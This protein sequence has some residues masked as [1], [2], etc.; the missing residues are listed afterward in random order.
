[1]RAL[2]RGVEDEPSPPGE[3]AAELDVLDRRAR[4]ASRV[5]PV[6]L[7][8]RVGA[9]RPE[10]GPEAPGLARGALVHRVV[11]EVPEAGDE[12]RRDDA[13]VVRAEHGDE[14]AVLGERG[15][16]PRERVRVDEDVGVEE[17][18]DVPRRPGRAVVPRGRRAGSRA[19]S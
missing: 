10:A 15:A 18:E 2:Q 3:A 1:M 11:E 9:H 5:E 13:V 7:G 4:V 16:N 17:D 19:A 8:E 12:T 6:D 14:V